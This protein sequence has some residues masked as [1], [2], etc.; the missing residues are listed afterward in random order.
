MP[1]LESLAHAEAFRQGDWSR[2]T[3]RTDEAAQDHHGQN[4]LPCTRASPETPPD[5]VTQ[6]TRPETS[7]KSGHQILRTSTTVD[8]RRPAR[9]P[10][11]HATATRVTAATATTT[12]ADDRRSTRESRLEPT[13]ARSSLSSS[14][15]VIGFSVVTVRLPHRATN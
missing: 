2:T 15:R 5:G 10:T 11:N 13:V 3:H 6:Q 4:D 9:R 7:R 14:S 8:R 12:T 1:D